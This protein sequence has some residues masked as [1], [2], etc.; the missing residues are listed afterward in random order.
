MKKQSKRFKEAKKVVEPDK[1][2]TIA[3]AI[4]LAKQT[5]T[6]KFDAGVEVHLRLGVDPKKAD[7]V[8]R[9]SVVLPHGTGKK[10]KI[11]VFAEGKDQDEAKKAG[12]ELVGGD[13]LIAEIKQTGKC[14]FEIAL[15]TPEMM[16]KMGQIARILGPKGLMPNPRSETVTKDV[17]KAVKALSEGKITFRNDDSGNIHQLVGKVSFEPKQLEENINTFIEAIKQNKPAGVKGTYIIS[18]SI[19]T[20]M[21]PSI[22]INIS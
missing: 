1:V 4:K 9:S 17:A 12:A 15:A 2:Y 10:K 20:T 18:S 7:Q 19:C 5:S 16:K 22:K 14:E 13:E 3:E 11:A 21:G 8:L 6:T